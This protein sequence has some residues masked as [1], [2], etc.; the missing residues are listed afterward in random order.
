MSRLLL[1][2]VFLG[3]IGVVAVSA[4]ARPQGCSSAAL[5]AEDRDASLVHKAGANNGWRKAPTLNR[6]D[7]SRRHA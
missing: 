3:G 5:A 1:R 4:S 6:L 7:G 2:N